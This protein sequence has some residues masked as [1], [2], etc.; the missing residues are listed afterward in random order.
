MNEDKRRWCPAVNISRRSE[1]C[2]GFGVFLLQPSPGSTDG[3]WAASAGGGGQQLKGMWDLIHIIQPSSESPTSE[4]KQKKRGAFLSA[5]QSCSTILLPSGLN[6]TLVQ[7]LQPHG[8]VWWTSLTFSS[9]R[10]RPSELS[11][12]N[13]GEVSARLI[14]QQRR[15]LSYS[16]LSFSIKNVSEINGRGS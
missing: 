6:Q 4:R 9:T 13:L 5:E 8:H 14:S 12:S 2:G 7:P 1:I 11:R 15:C 3:H 10:L 16:E